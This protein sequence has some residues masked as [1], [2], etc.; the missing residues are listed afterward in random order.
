MGVAHVTECNG[1]VIVG[2]QPLKARF[3]RRQ[4]LPDIGIGQYRFAEFEHQRLFGSLAI[5]EVSRDFRKSD[6]LTILPTQGG[7]DDIRPEARAIF[8]DPPPFVFESA[9][10]S[11]YL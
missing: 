1:R 7:D 6:E 4:H 8:A 5:G 9:F 10:C 11:G 3:N 2:D